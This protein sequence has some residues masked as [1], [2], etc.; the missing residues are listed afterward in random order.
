MPFY[1]RA[2][3]GFKAAGDDVS[4]KRVAR[5]LLELRTQLR[6]E[7]P[8][9]NVTES[10]L[11]ATWNLREFG[12]NK[13]FGKRLDESL[14][15]IAEIISHFDI[16]AIQEVNQN[17]AD[18]KLLMLLL[19]QWWEYLVTDVT[20]GRSGNEERIA[21]IYDGRKVQFD[22][23]A[24][25]VSL[26]GD[27]RPQRQPARSP[28]VCAF[29]SGWRRVT[30]CSV[31]IYYGTAKPNDSR[32]V[33]E[34]AKVSELLAQRNAN[35]QN[36]AD[37]EPE[38]VVLLG[39]FNIFN[40]EGDKTSAALERNHFVVPRSIRK[41]PGSNLTQDKY[42]DQIA[43]HDPRGRLKTTS[44]AGVLQFTKSIFRDA[45]AELYSDSMRATV[46]AQFKR[47]KD[48]KALYRKWRTFQISD[49]YPLWLELK[50]NFANAYLAT[51]AGLNRPKR[52]Q[53]KAS[54]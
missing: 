7:L 11:L 37:G 54:K 18:L 52:K 10:I 15:Y 49:H 39:D 28:F 31:H 1:K 9:R 5:T 46:P 48:H 29:R 33:T 23:L 19:G 25:E 32:R 44:K 20:P 3:D 42:F 24:G 6:R 51:I 43:F 21:F 35:R 30:L 12:A 53:R 34:I 17:L 4:A 41:A 45:D 47:T 22:H 26:P 40:K 16:I 38:N 27:K 36:I 14:L 8:Q 50:T 2:F 13:K